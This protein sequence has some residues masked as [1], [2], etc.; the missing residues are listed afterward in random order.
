MALTIEDF[1][2]QLNTSIIN[3]DVV[4]IFDT[5]FSKFICSIAFGGVGAL[6]F[7]EEWAA[8]F[9]AQDLKADLLAAQI[10]FQSDLISY[11]EEYKDLSLATPYSL[12]WDCWNETRIDALLNPQPILEVQAN[13][14]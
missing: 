1:K 11:L 2:E 10:G 7:K 3:A 8:Y 9:R 5:S 14:V 4:K 6:L 13:P 12:N